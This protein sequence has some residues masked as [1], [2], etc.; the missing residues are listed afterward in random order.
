MRFSSADFCRKVKKEWSA[1]T[2]IS[3][4]LLIFLF[5]MFSLESIGLMNSQNNVSY[6]L[7][8]PETMVKIKNENREVKITQQKTDPDAFMVTK[9]SFKLNEV[10]NN[11]LA[12]LVQEAAIQQIKY[13]LNLHSESN[14]IN[15]DEEDLEFFNM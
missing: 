10:K 6:R 1:P 4:L 5:L 2:L 7:A 3:I 8:S 15:E 9:I 11:R 13:E 14:F 12:E